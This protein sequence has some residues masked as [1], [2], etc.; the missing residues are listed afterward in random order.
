MYCTNCQTEN[1]SGAQICANC[2]KPLTE[3]SIPAAPEKQEKEISN[4][5]PVINKEYSSTKPIVSVVLA[6]LNFNVLGIIL[7]ILSLSKYNKYERAL[8]CG[9]YEQAQAYAK[10]SKKL[11]SAAIAITIIL[12]IVRPILFFA[13]VLVGANTMGIVGDG[14][15]ANNAQ[16]AMILFRT[17]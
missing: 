1:E 6:F 13:F 10:S 15:I 5:L 2:G 17:F 7:S 11:S 14:G 16:S 3:E 9:D 4:R 12:M 8:F